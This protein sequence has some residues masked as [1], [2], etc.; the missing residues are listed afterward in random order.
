MFKIIIYNPSMTFYVLWKVVKLVYNQK[1]LER[2][3]II[4]KGNEAELWEILDPE[5]TTTRCGGK[6][7]EPTIWFPPTNLEKDVLTIEDIKSQGIMTFDFIGHQADTKFFLKYQPW[8]EKKESEVPV[9]EGKT[10][11]LD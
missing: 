6:A 10:G 1:Y 3:R 9:W 2:V 4:K 5:Q 8:E 11:K 7:Q